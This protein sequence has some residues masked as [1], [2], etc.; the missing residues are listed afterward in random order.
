MKRFEDLLAWQQS[1]KVVTMIY[2][3]TR[4]ET[5]YKDYGLVNQLQRSAVSIMT[6]IAEGFERIHNKEKIQFYNVARA[7][8]G[9]LRSL[10]YVVKDLYLDLDQYCIVLQQELE[11]TGKLISGLLRSTQERNKKPTPPNP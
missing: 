9:E 11:V 3:L 6:N 8:G 10:I 4:H 1:R 7:S 5:I 2:Q